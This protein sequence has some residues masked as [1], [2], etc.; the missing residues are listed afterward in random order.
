MQAQK[1]TQINAM[2]MTTATAVS[3]EHH[4]AAM[5]ILI[6]MATGTRQ[7]TR[8]NATHQLRIQMAPVDRIEYA[9]LSAYVTSRYE[10][11]V[12]DHHFLLLAWFI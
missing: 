1:E 12:T 9:P 2:A 10:Q 3:A 11:V 6:R 8:K 7:A 4:S 5:D